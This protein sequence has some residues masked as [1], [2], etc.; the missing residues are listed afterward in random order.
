VG[1]VQLSPRLLHETVPSKCPQA[2]LTAAL[3]NTSAFAMLPGPANVYLNNSF[4]AKVRMPIV[5]KMTSGENPIRQ[6]IFD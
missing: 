6:R 5:I 1:V 2:F 3:T 4:V